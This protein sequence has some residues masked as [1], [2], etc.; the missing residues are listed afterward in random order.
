METPL[1]GDIGHVQSTFYSY[2][3]AS[4]ATICQYTKSRNLT[5]PLQILQDSVQTIAG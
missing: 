3:F 4:R 1:F 2:H 5:F